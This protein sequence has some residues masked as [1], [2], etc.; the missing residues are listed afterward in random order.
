MTSLP[1]I[2]IQIVAKTA[3][4]ALSFPS[5]CPISFHDLVRSSGQGLRV[6]A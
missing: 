1:R 2:T 6:V 3:S 4:C 5:C